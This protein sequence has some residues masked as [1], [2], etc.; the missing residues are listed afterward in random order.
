MQLTSIS[1]RKSPGSL[2]I[3]L[4]YANKILYHSWKLDSTIYRD[5]ET[6]TQNINSSGKTRPRPEMSESLQTLQ[7]AASSHDP[8]ST[9]SVF[10]TLA[11]T[12]VRVHV[13][14]TCFSF[15][16]NKKV[17]TQRVVASLSGDL[18]KNHLYMYVLCIC[19]Y[20]DIVTPLS[21]LDHT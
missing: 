10:C 1:Y 12:S 8:S 18:S 15:A 2:R 3:I 7:S 19:R 13:D 11:R 5:G 6:T 9:P 20:E 4:T 21:S 17:V 16:N 14:Y